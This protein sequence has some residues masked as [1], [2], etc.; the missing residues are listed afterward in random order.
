MPPTTIVCAVNLVGEPFPL[1]LGEFV[2]ASRQLVEGGLP[3]A[4]AAWVRTERA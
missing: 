1:P 3:A 4:T 2:L